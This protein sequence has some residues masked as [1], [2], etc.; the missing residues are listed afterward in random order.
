MTLPETGPVQSSA[1][2]ADGRYLAW[3]NMADVVISY[4]LKAGSTLRTVEVS[5]NAA[6][7]SVS[8]RGVLVSQ[9]GRLTLFGSNDVDALKSALAPARGATV[10]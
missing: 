2:S 3:L 8:D 6:I 4:D 10:L 1:L 9:A 5:R 7:T